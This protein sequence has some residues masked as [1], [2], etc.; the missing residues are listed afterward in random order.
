MNN[1]SPKD[2]RFSKIVGKE[3]LGEKVWNLTVPKFQLSKI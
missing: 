1:L 2:H 3:Q